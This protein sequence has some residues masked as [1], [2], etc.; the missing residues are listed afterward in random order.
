MLPLAGWAQGAPAP[1]RRVMEAQDLPTLARTSFHFGPSGGLNGADVRGVEPG[2]PRAT[3]IGL[4]SGFEAGVAG[5]WARGGHWALQAGARYTRQGYTQRDQ[6][7]V[8]NGA[9][10][11]AARAE[12]RLNYLT[13]P[14]SV[15]YAQF[16]NG[17]GIQ[18]YAGLYAAKFLAGRYETS[19][20]APG[21]PPVRG[22]VRAADARPV[23][24]RGEYVRPWDAGL[25]AG[26]GYRYGPALLQVGYTHGLRSLAPTLSGGSGFTAS[27]YYNRAVRLSLTY[28]AFGPRD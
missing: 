22:R 19:D 28:F 9:P 23:F 26:L 18:G 12:Y 7:L 6:V 5:Q 21:A 15:A 27:P 8:A 1:D 13:V 16:A 10:R 2:G 14:V 3:T 24:G 25:Q 11:V 17:Q 20:V 4:R